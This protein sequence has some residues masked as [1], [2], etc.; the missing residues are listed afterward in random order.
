MIDFNNASFMK[1]KPVPNSDFE[2]MVAPLFV[3]GEGILGT[4]RGM[5][6]GVVFTNKRI[7]AINVQG[8]TGKRKILLHFHI[9]KFRRFL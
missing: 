5:R 2:A 8:V 7:I 3:S 9:A 1:L 6:D 4:Y